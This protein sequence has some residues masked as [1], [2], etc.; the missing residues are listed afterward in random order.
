MCY[1]FTPN[2]VLCLA[3]WTINLQIVGGTKT[4]HFKTFESLL[5]EMEMPLKETQNKVLSFQ[6]AFRRALARHI[7]YA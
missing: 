3:A 1:L 7:N 2:S 4:I 6:S 5:E